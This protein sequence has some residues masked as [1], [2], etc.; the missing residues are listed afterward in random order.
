MQRHLRENLGFT[1]FRPGAIDAAVS[2]AGNVEVAA[3][4]ESYAVGS[5]GLGGERLRDARFIGVENAPANAQYLSETPGGEIEIARGIED[6][7]GD[8]GANFLPPILRSGTRPTT[9]S[10]GFLGSM[11]QMLPETRSQA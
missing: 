4:I 10:F 1:A 6:N 5:F 8:I 9:T 2:A 3:L 7:A 11:R